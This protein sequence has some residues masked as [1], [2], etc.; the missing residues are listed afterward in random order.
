MEAPLTVA[1]AARVLHPVP[2]TCRSR[3]TLRENG[4][5]V[6][7]PPRKVLMGTAIP[8]TTSVT[9]SHAAASI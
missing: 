2:M 4:Y 8:A 6:N 5:V 1:G 9:S 7:Q 3:D